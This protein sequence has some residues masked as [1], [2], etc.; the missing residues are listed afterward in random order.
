M[1]G[2]AITFVISGPGGVGKSTLAKLLAKSD[3][4]LELSISWTTRERRPGEEADA[5]CFVDR[6]EFTDKIEAGGFLEW[7]EFGGNLYGTPLPEQPKLGDLLL[8]IDVQGARQIK[9]YDKDSIV[10]LITGPSWDDI[11]KR[12]KARGD[13]PDQIAKRLEIGK[14]E[15][16]IGRQLADYI[17]VNQDLDGTLKTLAAI[18]AQTRSTRSNR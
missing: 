2:N 8:E 5:Y 6:K 10:V 14:Q 13:R 18:I 17:V 1:N 7:A 4:H 15:E 12:M 3:P 9:E 11:E 16:Q